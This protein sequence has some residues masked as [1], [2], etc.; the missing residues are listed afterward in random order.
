MSFVYHLDPRCQ[1]MLD[2]LL[3]SHTYITIQQLT[4]ELHISRRSVYYD[5]SKINEWLDSAS[6]AQIEVERSKGIFISKAHNEEIRALLKG[7]P[8]DSAYLFSPMERVKIIICSIMKKDKALY[9]ED[10][11]SLCQVSRNTIINDLKVV[12]KKLQEFNLNLVY[13]NK[14][15]YRIHGDSVR[16]RTVF[17]LYFNSLSDFYKK[18]ILPL[19]NRGTVNEIRDKL[20]SI[21]KKLRADYVSGVLFS[22]AVFFASIEYRTDIMEFSDKDREEISSTKEYKLVQSSF[23]T[24]RENDKLYLSL[25]L[26]GSR[27]QTV[28]LTMM[29]NEDK[30]T[31]DLAQSLV[32]EFSR[33]ACVD[34]EKVEEVEQA[35]YAHLKTS[36]YRYRYGIQLGNPMLDDIKNEYSEL[37]ELT[38]KACEYLEQQIGVPI[39]DGEI[40]YITLHFGGFMNISKQDDKFLS[41]LIVCPNGVS[42]GNMLRGEVHNL[43]PHA[44]KID[45]ISLNHYEKKHHYDVVISTV[46]IEGQDTLVVHPILTDN[47]RVIILRKCMRNETKHNIEIDDVV[48]LAEKYIEENKLSSFHEEMQRYLA[49]YNTNNKPMSAGSR[50]GF[51]AKLDS[52]MV[53]ICKDSLSFEEAVNF[54]AKPLLKSGAIESMYVEHIIKHTQQM[55]PYMIICDD[56]MLAHAKVEEGAN[57]LGL[58]MSVFKNEVEV[59]EGRKIRIMIVLSAE[60]QLKHLRILND[61]MS[62]FSVRENVVAIS[63]CNGVKTLLALLHNILEREEIENEK[64]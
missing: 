4:N 26:L 61:I 21:E 64:E 17:F 44:T 46:M 29:P 20:A 5:L 63:A 8:Q 11:I 57:R 13:E 31:F 59:A 48:A 58:A 47:D 43:V 16:K 42:T 27:L 6:V 30:E 10:F 1:D 38:K 36:L 52:S 54:A 49:N 3:M 19:D 2:R 41:V 55:G 15:G 40:A 7:I 32:E 33:L 45:V 12:S 22:I 18:D 28:N 14:K 23:S 56:V 60:D 62:I 9:I 24:L 53:R 51:L 37:F 39:P 34:F 25:H 50:I 35:L